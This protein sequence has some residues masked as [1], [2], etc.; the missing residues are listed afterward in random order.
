MSTE[1]GGVNSHLSLIDRDLRGEM[2]PARP[3]TIKDA[4][5]QFE[6]LM[7]AQMLRMAR[8][9]SAGW[10]GTGEDSTSSPAVGYAE[11][12]LAQKIADNGGLGLAAIVSRD[13]ENQK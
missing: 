4:A 9:E 8:D 6:G 2:E 13:L 3:G 12:A 5:R 7:I 10:L 11:E 1:V